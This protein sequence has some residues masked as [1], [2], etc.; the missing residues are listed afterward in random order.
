MK[1]NTNRVRILDVMRVI[2][3]ILVML[4]HYYSSSNY[5]DVGNWFYFGAFGVPLFFII[6]GFVINS[7]LV[8]T[9]NYKDFIVNRFIRLSPAMFICSTITFVFFSYF[10]VED[11]YEHSKNFMNYLIANIFI[12]P[13]IFNI[14]SGRIIYY[15]LDNAYWSLWVEVCFYTLIGFLYFL[16]KKKFI[17]HYI[18]IG[19]IGTPLFFLFYT[20]LGESVLRYY[21]SIGDEQIKYYKIIAR[22][23]AFFYE[24]T[25]FLLGIYLYQLYQNKH[26][27]KYITYIFIIFLFNI[28]KERSIEILVFSILVFLFLMIFIYRNSW[29]NFMTNEIL[30]KIGVAS[31]AMYLIHYHIGVVIVKFMNQ[32][33]GISYIYPI[34]VI[35]IVIIFGLLCY[36]YLE[37]RLIKIYKKVILG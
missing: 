26:R 17:M 20:S 8:R 31:Y 18:V 35:G 1:D 7:T 19:C 29:L 11:G 10:Y 22:S 2:A 6:S 34:I 24:W 30:C 5:P 12:V 9:Q 36:H 27:K 16:N 32:Y 4:H 13:H 33:W 23:F 14:L 21:F 25:W 28:L 15:Y 37:K 3:I